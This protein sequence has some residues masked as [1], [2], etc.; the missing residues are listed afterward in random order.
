MMHSSNC[1][2][3][4]PNLQQTAHL[5]FKHDSIG[6]LNQP[7]LIILEASGD[8]PTFLIWL[9]SYRQ[10]VTGFV[11]SSDELEYSEYLMG[12]GLCGKGNIHSSS[13]CD[14]AK[15]YRLGHQFCNS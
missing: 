1:V 12:F 8:H 6:H 4:T 14:T 2:T 15:I 7:V 5:H 3:P 13:I 9:Q 11:E 10:S